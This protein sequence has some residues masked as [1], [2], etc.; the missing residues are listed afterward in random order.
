MLRHFGVRLVSP[1]VT[2]LLGD[3]QVVLNE[4]Y[5]LGD[6]CALRGQTVPWSSDNFRG[7]NDE[8]LVFGTNLS[9]VRFHNLWCEL[10]LGLVTQSSL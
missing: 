9:Q 2:E 10:K 5:P 6:V 7:L 3:T 4:L 8:F 1:S